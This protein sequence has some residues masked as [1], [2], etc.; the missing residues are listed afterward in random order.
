MSSENKSLYYL[1][2]L[3][4][5]KVSNSDKD[6]RG[7]EVKDANSKVIGTVDNLLVNKKMERVVYLDV[8]ANDAVIKDSLSKKANTGV[9]DFINEDGENH[10]IIPIGMANLDLENEFVTS[11]N[12]SYDTFT[13]TK[14]IKK[15]TPIQRGYE[16]VVLNTYTPV[17]IA[18]ENAEDDTFYN[19]QEF[20]I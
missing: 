15:G 6:V 8:L 17:V 11:T 3:G 16:I 7:W 18:T 4:D 1:E 12:I 19:R 13:K 20:N 9:H 10:I 2:E 5:Y 14:R